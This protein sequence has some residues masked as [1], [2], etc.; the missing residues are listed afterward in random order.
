M[1]SLCLIA[2]NV[3]S[4]VLK[5]VYQLR[6]ELHASSIFGGP[7]PWFQKRKKGCCLFIRYLALLSLA[8]FYRPLQF[9][10]VLSPAFNSRHLFVFL[11]FFTEIDIL[12][13]FIPLLKCGAN[14]KHELKKKVLTRVCTKTKTLILDYR[15]P[16]LYA[17]TIHY[18]DFSQ[19]LFTKSIVTNIHEDF[20]PDYFSCHVQCSLCR[21]CFGK[22]RQ[23]QRGKEE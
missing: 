10:K 1:F 13:A 8:Q 11:S 17:S 5:V 23:Y 20:Y 12:V 14:S 18:G 6:S 21:Q 7:H 9:L 22:D 2:S 19:Q 16:F 15:K 3:I 4:I